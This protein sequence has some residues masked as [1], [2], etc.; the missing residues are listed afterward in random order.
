MSVSIG[1][2]GQLLAGQGGVIILMLIILMTGYRRVWVFGRE[3]Q[4]AEER[5]RQ[6]DQ[7]LAVMRQT[8]LRTLLT[9][10]EARTLGRQLLYDA[11][12]STSPSGGG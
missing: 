8:I 6:Q 4:Q 5:L 10:E 2:I 3:L 1:D 9:A 7:E 11:T 12:S